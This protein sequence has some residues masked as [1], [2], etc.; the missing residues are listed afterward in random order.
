MIIGYLHYSMENIFCL[1]CQKSA[2]MCEYVVI[3]HIFEDKYKFCSI[4]KKYVLS[5]SFSNHYCYDYQN[6]L[7]FLADAAVAAAICDLWHIVFFSLSEATKQYRV[8]KV[9]AVECIMHYYIWIFHLYILIRCQNKIE[10]EV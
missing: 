8:S 9:H 4:P 6:A 7:H 10:N 2:H 5:S 3:E 1:V